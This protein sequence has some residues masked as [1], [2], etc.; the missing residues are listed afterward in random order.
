MQVQPGVLLTLMLYLLSLTNLKV[1]FKKKRKRKKS[2]Y[3]NELIT[4]NVVNM[5]LI[6]FTSLILKTL[7]ILGY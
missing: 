6:N 4:F 2:L 3:S 1:M 7:F 5:I